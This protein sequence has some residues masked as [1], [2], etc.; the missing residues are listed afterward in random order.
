M[1]YLRLCSA[2][3]LLLA[4]LM[5]GCTT[6]ATITTR[7]VPVPKAPAAPRPTAAPIVFPRDDAPHDNLTEWWYYTGHLST[8]DGKRY[9]FEF[10]IFQSVRGLN[11]VA[12]AAHLAITDHQAR[13]FSF[14]HR[15]QVGSQIGK[16]DGV[17]LNVDGWTMRGASGSDRLQAEMPG[18]A[19]DLQLTAQKPAALHNKI[20]YIS[21]GPAGDSYYYSRTRLAVSGTL[22]VGDA[23]SPVTGTAWMD[24]QWGD[25]ISA[26]GGWDWFA[27]QLDDGS[28]VTLSRVRDDAGQPVLA[29]GMEVAPDG[30]TRHLE[31]TD[32]Q[33]EATGRW[34]SPRTGAVYPSG[35]QVQVRPAGQGDPLRLTL[36]PVLLDQEL[37]TRTTT[38]V[39]Y[40]EGEVAVRGNRAGHPVSGD[41]Y[42]E[43]TGY[44]R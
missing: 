39:V 28:E 36:E 9:G 2:V 32:F 22:R 44:A 18:Y 43:L 17:N 24:H 1:R 30:T 14:D 4:A 10:V 42:V 23:A 8:T 34:Q 13:R 27:V 19:I 35:W 20:G 29:Y 21:F 33:M 5:P 41:G 16:T 15:T 38:G 7:S 37:D 40:W 25:F 12:Y 31:A 3:L 11:P 6:D 26:G